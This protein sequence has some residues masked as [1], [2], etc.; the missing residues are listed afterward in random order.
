MSKLVKFQII[1]SPFPVTI[2]DAGRFGYLEQGIP[3]SGAMDLESAVIANKL[4]GKPDDN[5]VL[6]ITL[7]GTE[8]S[9]SDKC[10]IAITGANLS[11]RLNKKP[12]STWETISIDKPS[13]ISFGK[14]VS[15]CR[16]YLAFNGTFNLHPWLGSFS[17]FGKLTPA[18]VLK[19]GDS[20][21][22]LSSAS[23]S[24]KIYPKK[25]QPIF[26]NSQKIKILKGP[27]FDNFSKKQIDNFLKTSFTI[28]SNSNRM[29]Y[30]LT[31]GFKNYKQKK[32]LISSGVLPGTIQVTNAGH[33]TILMRDAQTTGGYPRIANVLSEDINKLAQM[34]AGDEIFFEIVSL[35]SFKNRF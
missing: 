33:L 7:S 21:E 35:E 17:A 27:E 23:V 24:K 14:A 28:A 10:Q 32:E 29:G 19:N 13:I 18:L 1:K 25:Y 34:K 6:E 30:N 4:V 26:L 11:P 8:I 9:I 15:G 22:G 31:E 20:I 3:I 12:I 2:Q 16:A 5:S